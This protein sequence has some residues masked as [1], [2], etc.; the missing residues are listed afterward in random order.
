M[1]SEADSETLQLGWTSGAGLFC[2]RNVYIHTTILSRIKIYSHKNCSALL[3][4]VT[5]EIKHLLLT[6]WWSSQEI[7]SVR[8]GVL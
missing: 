5:T 3:S 4:I 6:G 8:L 2:I 1:E 7:E